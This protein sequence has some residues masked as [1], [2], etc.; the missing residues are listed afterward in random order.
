MNNENLKTQQT[1]SSQRVSS[2]S[3]IKT[4]ETKPEEVVESTTP[5]LFIHGYSGG[6]YSF[7]PMIQRLETEN[8]GNKSAIIT[9][10][11]TG[12]VEET[13][14]VL[15]DVVNPMIQVLFEDNENTEWQQTE[16]LRSVL[17]YLKESYGYQTVNLVG[18]SMG[19]VS[20]LRY[21]TTYGSD[22]SLPQIEKFVAIGAPF[23]DF[24]DTKET[25]TIEDVIQHGPNQISSRYQDF[26]NG[27]MNIPITIRFLLIGGQLASDDPSDGTVPLSSALAVV[28]LLVE[29]GNSVAQTI[30]HGENAQHS[31]L[32]ENQQVD[33]QVAEFLWTVN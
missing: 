14:P 11:S 13:T 29:N 23:N 18:H 26:Q 3:S 6:V 24:L 30:I 25:Q 17:H 28:S 31:A 32:H 1:T 16:W 8:F 12:E 27:V 5:T 7:G 21:L 22:Q 2:D 33:Q 19:G 15:T 4:T 9:V 10:T 20:G